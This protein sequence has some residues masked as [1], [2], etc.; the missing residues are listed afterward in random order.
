M[1]LTSWRAP[2]TL[3]IH[4]RRSHS[5][6]SYLA[7]CLKLSNFVRLEWILNMWKFE[8][9]N[10]STF[11]F[12]NKFYELFAQPSYVEPAVIWRTHTTPMDKYLHHI[13]F[14]QWLKMFVAFLYSLSILYLYL[15]NVKPFFPMCF[16]FI[17]CIVF[18]SNQL[19]YLKEF[20][21]IIFPSP[22]V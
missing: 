3:Y 5:D 22:N 12:I 9:N 18:N 21:H 7:I 6:E 16:Q 20:I 11:T 19:F 14:L 15:E 10:T 2:G 1:T 8:C 17:V 4:C 13:V